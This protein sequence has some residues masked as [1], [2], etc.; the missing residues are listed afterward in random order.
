MSVSSAFVVTHGV[1][2]DTGSKEV[3]NVIKNTY[4]AGGKPELN[5]SVVRCINMSPGRCDLV[6]SFW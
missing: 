1:A 3:I 4:N 2:C 6:N 5:S